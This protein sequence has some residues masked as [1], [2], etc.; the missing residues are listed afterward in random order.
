MAKPV[1][2]QGAYSLGMKQDVSRQEL[3][4]GAVWNLQDYV[5]DRLGAPLEKRGAWSYASTAL[6]ASTYADAVAHVPFRSVGNQLVAI[7]QDGN[8]Y[9]VSV[10]I[11][12][13]QGASGRLAQLPVLYYDVLFL[14]NA[15]GINAPK[16]WDGTTLAAVA[17]SPPAGS[18]AVVFKNRLA[19]GGPGATLYFHPP[20]A[21]GQTWDTT[22]AV[23]VTSAPI[24]GLAS[25][26]SSILIFHP[27]QV[28]RLRGSIPAGTTNSDMYLEPL[29]T[30]MGCIDARSIVAWNDLIIWADGRGIYQTDGAVPLDLTTAAGMKG[31]WQSTLS[32][33]TTNW[34]VACGVIRDLLIVSVMNGTTFVDCFVIDLARRTF[35]RFKNYPFRMLAPSVGLSEE[36]YGALAG[37]PRIAALA[38]LFTP[39]IGADAD[40]TAILP[41]LETPYWKPTTFK[42]RWRY[43]YTGYDLRGDATIAVSATGSPTETYTALASYAATTDFTRKRMPVRF[44]S[45]G[46]ALKYA[47]VSASSHHRLYEIE[48]DTWSE[49]GSR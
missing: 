43:V 26:R 41:V 48:A 4:K 21:L 11:P 44:H 7:G 40:G 36:V 24:I 30:G 37:S 22:R 17:G 3:P 13:S 35:W 16:Q 25:Q 10:T 27:S 32:G 23:Y 34:T 20:G 29:F 38:G 5:P 47:Q 33:Y 46:L 49:E 2:L 1:L 19:L 28:E 31:M 45:H 39:G 12:T 8:F 18:K 42:K 6:G 14:P 15:D 9:T